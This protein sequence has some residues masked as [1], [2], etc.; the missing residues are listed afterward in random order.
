VADKLVIRVEISQIVEHDEGVEK[1]DSCKEQQLRGARDHFAVS[2]VGTEAGSS[3]FRLT[4]SSERFNEK[5]AAAMLIRISSAALETIL[6]R[7]Q[8]ARGAFSWYLSLRLIGQR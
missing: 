8:L 7:V 1:C 6:V 4:W 5:S 2:W 3:W